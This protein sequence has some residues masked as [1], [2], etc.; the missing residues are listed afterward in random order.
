[1][2]KKAKIY[3]PAKNAMQSGKANTRVWLLEYEQESPRVTDDLMGWVGSS[4]MQQEL[5][6]KFPT[7]EE[8]VHYAEHHRIPYDLIDPETP[9]TIIRPYAD[10]FK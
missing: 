4:D 6:L 1:M 3:Q 10:N 7:K 5:R 2:K 9:K 8:A